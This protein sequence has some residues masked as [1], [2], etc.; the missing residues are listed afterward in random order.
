[1][2]SP[3]SLCWSN[4][5]PFPSNK[6]RIMLSLQSVETFPSSMIVFSRSAMILQQISVAAFNIST[7]TPKCSATFPFFSSELCWTSNRINM[8]KVL[9][10]QKLNIQQSLNNVASMLDSLMCHQRKDY[11][12]ITS[13][14]LND[15]VFIYKLSSCWFEPCCSHLIFRYC[16]CFEQGVPWHSGNLQV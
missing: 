15:W 3:Q 13:V 1:M 6:L 7:T 11:T 12:K 4:T 10:S 8:W 2:I 16:T 9:R 14:W 5:F